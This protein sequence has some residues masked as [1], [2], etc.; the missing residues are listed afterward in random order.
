MKKH[1]LTIRTALFY[2][3]GLMNTIFIKPGNIGSWINYLGYAILVI[4]V[5]DTI[6][7]V[8]KYF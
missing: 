6:V 1:W 8:R 2:F 3:I 5:F 7:I 4:A